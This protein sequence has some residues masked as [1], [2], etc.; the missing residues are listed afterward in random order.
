MEVIDEGGE[1]R[2]TN[3]MNKAKWAQLCTTDLLDEW[4]AK[5][6][7]NSKRQSRQW[8]YGDGSMRDRSRY[9]GGIVWQDGQW[10]SDELEEFTSNSEI[11][12]KRHHEDGRGVWTR[13]EDKCLGEPSNCKTLCCGSRVTVMEGCRVYMIVKDQLELYSK[14]TCKWMND[15]KSDSSNVYWSKWG[16]LRIK[17]WVKRD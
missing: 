6:E 7:W 12:C 5:M 15:R 4:R 13:G 1:S 10:P 16:P 2:K 8:H 17:G 9:T 3:R 14:I 11:Q